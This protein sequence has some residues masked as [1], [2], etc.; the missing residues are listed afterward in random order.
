VRSFVPVDAAGYGRIGA[1]VRHAL[2]KLL[3]GR[4]LKARPARRGG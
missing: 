3:H 2:D 4:R 1:Y